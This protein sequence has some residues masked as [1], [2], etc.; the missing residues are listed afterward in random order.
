VQQAINIGVNTSGDDTTDVGVALGTSRGSGGTNIGAGQAGLIMGT[1]NTTTAGFHSGSVTISTGSGSGAA[2]N[3]GS[4]TLAT[5]NATG[6][7]GGIS[8]GDTANTKIISIGGAI[9]GGTDTINIGTN[10]TGADI[11]TVGSTNASSKVTLVGGVSSTTNNVGIVLGS[12]F[13]TSDTSQVNLVLDSST[14]FA[15]T[16][17]HCSASVNG[18]A[19]YYNSATNAIRTCISGSGWED[20]MTTAGMGILMFGVV[21]DSGPDP[22]NW[23]GTNATIANNG[24]CKVYFGSAV[25]T[26]RWTGCT[27]YSGGRK[28]I[29]AAQAS[30]VTLT[31]SAS[32]WA[33]VCLTGANGQP[34]AS[35]FGTEN[36][37]LPTFSTTA[38]VLCLA[39]IATGTGQGQ[40]TGIYDT[41]TFTTSRKEIVNNTTATPGLGMIAVQSAT[42]G[43]VN[44][45]AATNGVAFVRGVIVAATSGTQTAN[46]MNTIIAT[47]G[48]AYVKATAGSVQQFVTT[49]NG[50]AGLA[51][52]TAT[53]PTLGFANLGMALSAFSNTCATL[54]D[55]CRGSLAV[56]LNLR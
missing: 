53:L 42:A 4:I 45:A 54:T 44:T 17:S 46:A 3:S 41:R 43:Q 32:S 50:R 27:A 13:S 25:K 7:V 19:L 28:V 36:A 51:L 12:G 21:P 52:T 2:T 37:N 33:H 24:P 5:G 26:I 30:D 6:T 14:T 56:N 22:G 34:Q 20:V 16:S 48:P 49:G 18:G 11:I 55:N 10:A 9:N 35:A 31:T 8:I 15:E 47:D 39:D 23:V 38:P 29:V 1:G 40:I